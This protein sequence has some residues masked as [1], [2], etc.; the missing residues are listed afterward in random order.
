[1][2]EKVGNN[3]K[4]KYGITY[5]VGVETTYHMQPK[6]G[7]INYELA[8]SKPRKF[9]REVVDQDVK[10]HKVS[11]RKAESPKHNFSPKNAK[12]SSKKGSPRRYRADRLDY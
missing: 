6:H 12:N 8:N 5:Q 3:F 11:P 4:K 7:E 1:M 10:E 9:Y 2:A